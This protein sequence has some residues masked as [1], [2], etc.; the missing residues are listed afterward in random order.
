[1]VGRDE[2]FGVAF[3]LIQSFQYSEFLQ[4]KFFATVLGWYECRVSNLCCNTLEQKIEE[5]GVLIWICFLISLRF[6]LYG[7]D[8]TSNEL[9]SWSWVNVQGLSVCAKMGGKKVI[10]SQHLVLVEILNRTNLDR[11]NEQLHIRATCALVNFNTCWNGLKHWCLTFLQ[12]DVHTVIWLENKSRFQYRCDVLK[13]K[14]KKVSILPPRG[15]R[16][17]HNQESMG[18]SGWRLRSL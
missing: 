11:S 13:S 6:C 12:M 3:Y 4:F 9:E 5:R 1:M 8:I 10:F 7:C 2:R 18:V 14:G 17:W 16:R 15:G